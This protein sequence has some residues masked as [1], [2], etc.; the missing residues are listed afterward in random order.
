[1]NRHERRK[2]KK[3]DSFTVIFFRKNGW[4]PVT[5]KKG[6]D[7]TKHIDLNPGTE[8]VEDIAGNVLWRLQ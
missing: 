6:E 8:R 1:M 4:Y 3:A 7:F 2:A 5:L